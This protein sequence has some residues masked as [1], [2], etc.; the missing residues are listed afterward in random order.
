[1]RNPHD[2]ETTALLRRALDR[3]EEAWSLLVLH[4]GGRLRALARHLL[5]HRLQV[6]FDPEDVVQETFTDA[7]LMLDEFF[8]QPLPFPAWLGQRLK[9]RVHRLH[10]D[11]LTTERRSV[12][13][14]ARLA[15]GCDR[16]LGANPIAFMPDSGT[17]P[18]GR[19]MRVEDK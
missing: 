7:F 16:G 2:V 18:S 1:M 11:H 15:R 13:R 8:E 12:R 3:D 6:R 5:D 17:S 10:R 14:E 9:D 4:H 19:A